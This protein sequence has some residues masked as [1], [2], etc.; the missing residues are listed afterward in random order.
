MHRET[1]TS[2]EYKVMLQKERFIGTEEQLLRTAST[3]WRS[4]KD[5]ITVI[6]NGVDGDLKKITDRR[7]IKFYDTENHLLYQEHYIFRERRDIGTG[8]QEV[9]L[10]FR[11]LD[12]Y[13]SQD[14]S[15]KASDLNERCPKF[16]EDIKPPF[17]VLYSFSTTQPLS[18]D[19][20]LNTLQ[21]IAQLYPDFP[22]ELNLYKGEESLQEVGDTI[23]ELVIKGARFRIR[24]QPQMNSE[25]AL[26]VWYDKNDREKPVV[27]EFSFRYRDKHEGYTQTVSQRAYD[28]FRVLQEH[29]KDWIAPDSETKTAYIYS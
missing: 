12:R 21:D 6:V 18:H 9:T 10:K 20:N 3:F 26:I 23:H 4:F 27:V 16:E 17:S 7:E 13:I 29:L 5:A 24:D 25:C 15:M 8:K 11:H 2:R 22:D 1:V 19:R 14:R 28:V